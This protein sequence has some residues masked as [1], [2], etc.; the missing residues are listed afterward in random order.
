MYFVKKFYKINVFSMIK[1]TKIDPNCLKIHYRSEQEGFKLSVL[2]LLK[3]R[4]SLSV[5]TF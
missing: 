5:L 1:Q 4:V 3:S 2:T